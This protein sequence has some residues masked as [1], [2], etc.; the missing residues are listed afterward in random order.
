MFF[1]FPGWTLFPIRLV[2][3]KFSEEIPFF[4][5]GTFLLSIYGHKLFQVWNSES[6]TLS[7][8][9]DFEVAF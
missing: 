8:K 1:G 3:I 2:K 4:F 9:L 7:W 6:K 5:F